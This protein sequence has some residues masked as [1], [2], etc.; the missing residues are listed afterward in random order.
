MANPVGARHA[1]NWA[2]RIGADICVGIM[3]VSVSVDLDQNREQIMIEYSRPYVE[4]HE[5]QPRNRTDIL[6]DV[7]EKLQETRL[8]AFGLNDKLFLYFIDMAIFHASEMLTNQPDLGEQEKW[9]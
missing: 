8:Q 3:E 5:L 7:A 9:S 4:D 1:S 2:W 6:T